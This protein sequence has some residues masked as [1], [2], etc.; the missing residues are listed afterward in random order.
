MPFFDNTVKSDDKLFLPDFCNVYTVFL[1]IIV[2]ELLAFILVFIPLGKIGY[3]WKYINS[4]L[5]TDLAMVS[6]FMQW[7]TLVSM[8]LLCVFRQPL[9]ELKIDWLVGLFSYILILTVTLLVSE[10]AWALNEY[11]ISDDLQTSY[12]H[13][14]FLVKNLG[15]S[16]LISAVGFS[17][18]YYYHWLKTSNLFLI[19]VIILGATLFI[20]ELIAP[21]NFVLNLNLQPTGHGLFLLRNLLISAIISAIAL[22]YFYI[23]TQ[24]QRE[25]EATAYAQFQALR[26]R[27]DPHFLFN[28]MNTIASLISIDPHCA[29]Q[30]VE[31]LAD[32]FRVVLSDTTG[33]V[34]WQDEVKLCTQYLRIETLRLGKRLQVNWD[35][36]RIPEDAWFPGMC[37][38]PLLENA[39]YHGIQSLPAG[40]VINLTGHFDGKIIQVEITNP[41]AETWSSPQGHQIAQTNIRQRL[42]IYYGQ[43][44]E[45]KIDQ[46]TDFYYVML[47][48][49]YLH[50]FRVDNFSKVVKS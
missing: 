10:L 26:A 13:Y 49:P 46:Q 17:L 33:L 35:I 5:L 30:V 22:R 20:S 1:T 14:W 40:G 31:D 39:I 6:W 38:Q 42:Q 18:V 43:Q 36:D 16:T 25:V 47:R 23:Q 24:W 32:L 37:L 2:V 41:K 12:D 9:A 11:S 45:I 29:E 34:R 3:N 28:S 27:I 21:I 50:D 8:G 4:E 7:V 48:F 15:V 19:Y 44:A